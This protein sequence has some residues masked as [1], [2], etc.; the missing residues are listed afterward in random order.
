MPN[1]IIALAPE[2]Y[3]LRSMPCE[4]SRGHKA[5]MRVV[6]SG[7]NNSS[8]ESSQSYPLRRVL[9]PQFVESSDSRPLVAG[10][11]A[12]GDSFY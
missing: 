3:S 10:G 9:V 1:V 4:E 6:R 2:H 12:A 11:Q 5:I 8:L 7:L